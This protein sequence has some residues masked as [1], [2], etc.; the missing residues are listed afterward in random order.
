MLITVDTLRADHTSAFGYDLDTTPVLAALA[1][2]GFAF[3][4]ALA[5]QPETGPSLASIMTSRPPR[6]IG[7]RANGDVLPA[8]FPTLAE[9]FRDAG[10][11]TAAFVSTALL[12]PRLC[13]LE[14]GFGTYD[15]KMMSANLGH[16]AFE[17]RAEATADAAVAWLDA[18]RGRARFL[19]LHLY[20]P[21]GKYDPGPEL[22]RRFSRDTGRPPLDP[23]R[24]QD[25]QRFGDSLDPDDYVARYDGEI[26]RADAAVGR[27]LA[28]AGADATVAF[29]ADHGEG[30]GEHDYWFRHGSRLDAPALRVP[31]VLAGP[32]VP[33]G[34]R[35]H[36]LVRNLDLAP[37]LLD[38]VGLE[39]FGRGRSLR[40]LASGQEAGAP[41]PAFAEA[42]PTGLVAITSG[43]YRLVLKP[44]TGGYA[45]F[46]LEA[47]P[48]E[49]DDRA[50]E[51][52]EVAKR[53]LGPLLDWTRAF[54]RLPGA[55]PGEEDRRMIESHG[56]VR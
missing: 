48:G 50:A 55:E 53:L 51:E 45:L 18:N 22:A 49:A 30:L 42:R 36:V 11:A 54:D 15:A 28:A 27:V 2:R 34:G 19:W 6:E 9:R 13:G 3:D 29:T 35:S 26:F 44:S 40:P 52:P 43:R 25:Y 32:G 17:R 23:A 14:R 46:D 33:A 4:R 5:A 16:E 21:H 1:A 8:E 39:P 10:Y 12:A 31:L 7:V 47:D 24:L 37:T 41:P 20:D 56:Y 38:L